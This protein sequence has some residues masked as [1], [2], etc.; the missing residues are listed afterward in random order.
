LLRKNGET[1][2]VA[3]PHPALGYALDTSTSGHPTGST[4]STAP[5]TRSWRRS[6]RLRSG[7]LV[8][9]AAGASVG[10]LVLPGTASANPTP[11]DLTQKVAA[12]SHQ[13]EVV[14]EQVNQA[15]VALQ[16]QQTAAQKAGRAAVTAHDR[17]RAMQSKVAEIAR[18][19]YTTGDVSRLDVLLTSRSAEDLLSQMGTL[20]A[21]AGHQTQV[22]HQA[23]ITARTAQKAQAEADSAA[24]A[25]S[26]TLDEVAAEQAQLKARIA[27]YKHQ[28]A[29]LSARQQQTVNRAVAGRAVAAPA[30]PVTASSHTAGSHAASSHAAQVAVNTALAQVG[31]PYVWGASGPNS[32][33]CSGLTMYAYSAAG[34]SLPHSSSAQSTMGTPVSRSQLRPGDLVFFYSP[35]SHVG[36][37]IGNGQMVHASTAGEP[38][39]VV[40]LDSMP[41]YNS[42][43]RIAG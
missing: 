42:A 34:V 14:S 2:L 16:Q 23:V 22:L 17:L 31:K 20:D 11:A 43:R 28:Y 5:A 9:L 38:V 7:A 15:R 25:A 32:F 24:R 33:D 12:A 27:D 30:A 26:R 10:L 41:D 36:M 1:P 40:S 18:T 6:G 19:A 21:I 8:G 39:K 29:A 35:V 13:L 4:R 3:T 37:Y